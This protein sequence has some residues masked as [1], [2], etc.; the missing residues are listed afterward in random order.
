MD[1]RIDLVGGEQKLG[2]HGVAKVHLDEGYVFAAG[3]LFNPFEAG[4]VAIG[5]VVRHDHIV[6]CL[7]EFDCHMTAYESGTAGH[8]NALFHI[9]SVVN[10]VQS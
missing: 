3:D 8:E 9:H 7:N 5:H 6:A 10:E 1:N 2:S 4:H